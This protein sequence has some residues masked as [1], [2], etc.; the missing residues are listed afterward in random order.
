MFLQGQSI[1]LLTLVALFSTLNWY[2]RFGVRHCF[3]SRQFSLV[4][5]LQ[6]YLVVLGLNSLLLCNEI[7]DDMLLIQLQ[8]T[9]IVFLLKILCNLLDFGKCCF[10]NF[11]NVLSIFA[12]TLTEKG[13][14]N[15]IILRFGCSLLMLSLVSVFGMKTKR[16]LNPLF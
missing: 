3:C 5:Q 4:R 13:G 15:Q 10:N 9:F 16:S 11:T 1:F 14:L 8:L 7:I 2:I 6:P 12:S